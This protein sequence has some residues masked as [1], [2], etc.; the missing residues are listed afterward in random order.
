VVWNKKHDGAD[1]DEKLHKLRE[2]PFDRKP[3]M[4]TLPEDYVRALEARSLRESMLL[5]ASRELTDGVIIEEVLPMICANAGVYQHRA[6]PAVER[7]VGAPLLKRRTKREGRPGWTIPNFLKYNPS[8]DQVERRRQ[9]ESRLAWL[10]N[11]S[12]GRTARDFIRKRDQNRCRYCYIELKPNDQKSLFR[13]TYDHARPNEAEFDR[14]LRWIV[15]AC[16]FHNGQKLNRTPEEAGLT[17]L[18]PWGEA[19]EAVRRRGEEMQEVALIVAATLQDDADPAQEKIIAMFNEVRAARSNPRS[20]PP[21]G[22]QNRKPIGGRSG[23]D[24]IS[25]PGRDGSERGGSALE[26]GAV[27]TVDLPPPLTDADAPPEDER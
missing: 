6:F 13:A 22:D 21:G 1:L 26:A 12:P 27:L 11:T 25:V 10:Q 8:K 20:Q 23:R 2:D 15:Q 7:L 14:D 19:D 18:P 4:V 9:A 5:Y 17:L 16:A 24:P 3:T